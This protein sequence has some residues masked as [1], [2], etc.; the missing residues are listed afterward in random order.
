VSASA[1]LHVASVAGLLGAPASSSGIG[2]AAEKAGV[3][4]VAALVALAVLAR[5]P[6]APAR[7]RALATAGALV[8]TPVLLAVDVWHTSQLTHLRHHP[9]VAVAAGVAV[10]AVVAGL[11]FLFARRPG[12]FPVLVILALPFRV[13]VSAGGSTS[14]LL[15]P[16]YLVIAGGAFARLV[17]D[18]RGARDASAG[19]DGTAVLAIPD[20]A[21]ALPQAGADRSPHDARA[22]VRGLIAPR[23]LEWLLVAAVL[24]YAVGATYSSDFP[25]ALQNVAFFYAPFALLF[26]LLRDVRWST[27]LLLRCL[28]VAVAL[29]VLFVGIG[30]V[31]YGRQELFLN[32]KL[33]QAN[34]YGNYFRVNSVFFDP[35]IYGRFLALVMIAVTVVVLEA[36]RRR[37]LLAAA[38]VLLW[39]W[40]GLITSFSESSM[41]A[42]LLGLAV[43]AAWRWDTLTTVYV[44]LAAGILALVVALAAPPSAH[45]GLSGEGGSANNATSGRAK[46]VSGGLALFADRPLAGFGSGSFA[47]EYRRHHVSTE[48]TAV[49][50]S[51]TIPITVAAEQGIV[52]LALYV[53]LLVSALGVLFVGT[54]RAPPR[55]AV[56]ACFAALLLHTWVY[57]DFLE[58]PETWTLLG[59]GVALASAGTAL[60]ERA[61]HAS[62]RAPAVFRRPLARL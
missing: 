35:N 14:N 28:C 16:L 38:A 1:L 36:R 43:L 47:L 19:G 42:L 12:A 44:T 20:H 30:F 39:L 24:L 26:S 59:I 15:I 10:L 13:P 4:A 62:V 2:G 58:D 46:L 60:R 55:I 9:P 40:G 51:H 53:G 32:P 5:P 31:E 18:F 48:E 7:L 34:Q 21:P 49:S 8:L 61:G 27:E 56:A 33:V 6:R 57:A 25:K 17:A 23:T 37:D 22:F 50:A 54:G 3:V 11:A 52:G 29:A 41:A 45:F